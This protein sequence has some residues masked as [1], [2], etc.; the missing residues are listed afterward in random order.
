MHTETHFTAACSASEYIF[1]L[2]DRYLF[3][4]LKKEKLK[5]HI[6]RIYPGKQEET[7]FKIAFVLYLSMKLKKKTEPVCLFSFI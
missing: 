5:I 3:I 7:H 4:P 2:F 6:Q 1:P